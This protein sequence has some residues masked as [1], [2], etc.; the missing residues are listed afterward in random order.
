LILGAGTGHGPQGGIEAEALGV[1]DILVARQATVEGL[2]GQ[3]QQAVLGVL[4][5]AGLVQAV[6]RG[7]AQSERIIEFPVGRSPASLV[8]VE[9]WNSSLI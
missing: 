4:S 6:G 7:V 3:S 8:T 5:G 9:P 2:A 1:I